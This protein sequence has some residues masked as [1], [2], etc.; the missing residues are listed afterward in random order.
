MS[1]GSGRAGGISGSDDVFESRR[2]VQGR[3]RFG[4]REFE[5]RRRCRRVDEM[6]HGKYR[7]FEVCRRVPTHARDAHGRKTHGNDR[8]AEKN[9]HSISHGMHNTEASWA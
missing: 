7:A 3:E 9:V 1:A 4:N 8:Q 5:L 2:D 6:L